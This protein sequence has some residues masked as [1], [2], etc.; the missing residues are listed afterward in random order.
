MARSN[1]N[2]WRKSLTAALC[3]LLAPATVLAAPASR[4]NQPIALDA[5]SSDFDYKNNSLRFREIRLSQGV[6]R[7]EAKEAL[8]TG[9]NFD[10]SQWTF[11]GAV[12]ITTA[13]GTLTS[14]TATVNFLNNTLARALINGSP[15]TFSQQRPPATPGGKPRQ[16]RGAAGRIDYDLASGTVRLSESATLSD[17]ANEITGRTLVYGLRDQRVLA[18]PGEQSTERVRITIQP[19]TLGDTQGTK[20][21]DPVKEGPP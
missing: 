13:D 14:D 17:G 18:N 3:A 19:G 2:L 6:L 9:L 20:A 21:P 4:A 10:N 8:A 11:H 12:K 15:A 1:N 16:V 5:A 7:V